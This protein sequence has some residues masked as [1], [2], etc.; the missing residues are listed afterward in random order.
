MGKGRGFDVNLDGH[1]SGFIRLNI[2]NKP[3][4]KSKMFFTFFT[5]PVL[6]VFPANQIC[7]RQIQ[8]LPVSR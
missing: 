4:L 7:L 3:K 2:E 5:L 6:S 8:F 1:W